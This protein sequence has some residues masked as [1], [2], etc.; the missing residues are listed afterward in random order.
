MKIAYFDCISGISGDM[1][2][3]ALLDLGLPLESLRQ[4]LS[5]LG[6]SGYEIKCDKVFKNGFRAT[7][8]DVIVSDDV[9][10]RHF[11]DIKDIINHSRLSEKIRQRALD[12]FHR[13]AEVEAEIHGVPVDE[14]HLHEVGGLDTIIDVAGTLIGLELLGIDRVV[15]SPLPLGRGAIQGAHGVIPLPAPAALGL[16]KGAPVVGIDYAFEFVTPT[17]AALL[18]S[19]ADS[20]GVIPAMT[21]TSIGYGAGG[22][23]LPIPNLLR[24]I[25]GESPSQGYSTLE[26]LAMIETNLDD[27]NPQVYGYVMEILFERGALD[28]TF[29]PVQMKKNR[30][31]VLIS[32]LC[33]PMDAQELEH[34]LYS[35]TSTIGIRRHYVE[36]RSLA[37]TFSKVNTP[38]GQV[39]I[40]IVQ[41]AEGNTRAS[42]EYE[43]CHRLAA[44][45]GVPL[46]DIY[47]AAL[48]AAEGILEN[49]HPSE[50]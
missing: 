45:S 43:D 40:K 38:Y 2:L 34:I 4:E 13:L 6:I 36:R 31:G 16:L 20:F 28:V 17:G 41:V 1:I 26:T 29:T 24:I 27:L 21:L 25:I 50:S 39:T 33:R 44:S 7:K 3:G 46:L 35:E 15:A 11:S 37:R 47:R 22:R 32:V 23:D 5:A 14:V 19:L 12:V 10:E 42:P 8:C 18:S 49:T 48:A 30:P 9:H